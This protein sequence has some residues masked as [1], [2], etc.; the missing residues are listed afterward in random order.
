MNSEHNKTRIFSRNKLFVLLR[1]MFQCYNQHLMAFLD[2]KL[3]FVI[4]V[5]SCVGIIAETMQLFRLWKPKE[6][7]IQKSFL[8]DFSNLK[9]KP[10]I[11]FAK[12]SVLDV[13][14]GSEC[15]P[16]VNIKNLPTICLNK[17][18]KI[19]QYFDAVWLQEDEAKFNVA[20]FSNSS[21]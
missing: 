17:L 13:L 7:R 1:E 3:L 9:L 15:T 11:V 10:L 14:P 12:S 18:V 5:Y 20:L 21:L 8:L 19:S 6:W 4:F 16:K 2:L